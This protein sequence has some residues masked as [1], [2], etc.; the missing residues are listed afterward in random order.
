M[1]WSVSVRPS[2]SVP[3]ASRPA[4]GGR[5]AGGLGRGLRVGF[6]EGLF[7]IS[8]VAIFFGGPRV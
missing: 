4:Q 1:R 2:T 5:G 8:G 6:Y 3:S 7:K